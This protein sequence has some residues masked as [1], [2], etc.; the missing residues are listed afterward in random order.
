MD[1]TVRKHILITGGDGYIGHKV[2]QAIL[3]KTP[4]KLTLWVRALNSEALQTKIEKINQWLKQDWKE[5]VTI[6]GGDLAQE[7]PFLSVDSAEITHIL[8]TA[9]VIRF[10]LEEEIAND[11]NLLGSSKIMKF[12]RQC[13]QLEAFHYIS[14]VYSSG[15]NSGEIKEEVLDTVPLFVN[16]YERSKFEAE[17]ILIKEF[18][19]LPWR[20]LRLATVIADDNQ[21]GIT[22]Y[23]VFHNTMRLLFNGLISLLPGDTNTPLYLVTGEFSAASVFQLLEDS[24]PKTVY[25]ICHKKEESAILQELINWVFDVFHEYPEF[26]QKRIMPPI[27]ADE[28]TFMVLAN[29]MQSLSKGVLSDALGSITPFAKQLYIHKDFENRNLTEQLMDY[30]APDIESLIKNTTRHLVNTK[31]GR[32]K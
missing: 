3:N 11:V 10:N 25:H 17:Q 1:Q 8:H 27:F 16:H 23:N 29:N 19:D 2:A 15:M 4:N 21:G 31:W 5:R 9:A 30:R 28:K 14:T 22:Q 32:K 6:I 12:A 18:N 24:K 13:P 20:I 7:Q 26:T